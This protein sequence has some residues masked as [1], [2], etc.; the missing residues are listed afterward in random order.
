MSRAL[1]LA[2][3][4]S[5]S[6]TPEQDVLGPCATAG[7]L[8][9]YPPT[10]FPAE[11]FEAIER[12]RETANAATR[13]P[14][15][16]DVESPRRILAWRPDEGFLAQWPPG[17]DVVFVR[18][19]LTPEQT[20]AVALHEFLHVHGAGHVPVPGAVLCSPDQG[21]DCAGL[22]PTSLTP[23]DLAELGRVGALP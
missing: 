12:A 18:P 7:A 21:V 9:F 16:Y 14:I 15:V 20:E 1:L 8:A 4:L 6:D 17:Y 22:F 5:C 10:G 3:L 2:G 13:E 23:A 11:S 19:D